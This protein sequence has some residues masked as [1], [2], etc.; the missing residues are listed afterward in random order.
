MALASAP[1]AGLADYW[2]DPRKAARE[3]PH[4]WR[5]LVYHKVETASDT[6]R[7]TRM[8]GM[9]SVR[10]YNR[11]KEWGTNTKGYSFSAGE[12]GRLGRLRGT[13]TTEPTSK[14]P[15]LNYSVG[16]TASL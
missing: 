13:S 4:T 14:A 1:G 5:E 7:A 6:A 2:D 8:R 12:E 9:P 3:N 11:I 15:A 16:S 10:V